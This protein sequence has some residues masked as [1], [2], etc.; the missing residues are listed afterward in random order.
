MP[1]YTTKYK[2]SPVQKPRSVNTLGK[3]HINPRMFAVATAMG[4]G[5]TSR[6]VLPRTGYVHQTCLKCLLSIPDE[7]EFVKTSLGRM[8]SACAAAPPVES[9]LEAPLG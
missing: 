2:E 1:D 8:H 9:T 3:G 4:L 5:L 7:Q 6:T